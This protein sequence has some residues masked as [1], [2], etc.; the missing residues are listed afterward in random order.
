[1]SDGSAGDRQPATTSAEAADDAALVETTIARRTVHVGRFIRFRVDTVRGPDGR[2]HQREIVDHPGAVAIVAL[3][4]P[5]LLLVRQFRSAAQRILLEI[6]AGTLDRRGD[7]TIEPPEEAAPRELAEETGYEAVTWR[8]LG[9]FWTAPGFASEA[10]TLYLAT[11]LRP[12]AA[13]AGPEEDEHLRLVRLPVRD[14][15]AEVEAGRIEDAKTIIGILWLARVQPSLAQ[16]RGQ[17]DGP[18]AG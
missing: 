7:G 15:L 10:M 8:R 6:P 2:Q 16:P 11:D 3:D 4:G 1:M 13:Y 5:D 18:Q 12:V 14:A 9:H 17:I